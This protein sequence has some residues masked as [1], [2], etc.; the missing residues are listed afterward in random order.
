MR[1]EQ[2]LLEKGQRVMTNLGSGTIEA[3]EDFDLH[4]SSLTPVDS[5]PGYGG[6]VIV[7]LDEPE[8]WIGAS[9]EFPHPYIFRGE[10]GVLDEPDISPE[11]PSPGA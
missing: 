2:V 3:F 10:I 5:D 7:R 8:K 6:R 4:G 9:S 11:A 1:R